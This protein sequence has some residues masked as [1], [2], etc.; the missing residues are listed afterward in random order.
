MT[1]EEASKIGN[2]AVVG[3]CSTLLDDFG[4]GVPY[5]CA[6]GSAA[7]TLLFHAYRIFIKRG[8]DKGVEVL[9]T[10]L[11]DLA[12]NIKNNGGGIVEFSVAQKK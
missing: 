6:V 5:E 8:P 4:P 11:D 10:I 1:L 9:K 12:L 2:E 3:M 7:T